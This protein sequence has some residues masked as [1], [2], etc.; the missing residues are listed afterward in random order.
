MRSTPIPFA[1]LKVIVCFFLLTGISIPAFAK[2][3]ALVIGNDNYV[4]VTKLKKAGNDANAMATE[5]RNAGFEVS[6]HKDLTYRAMVKA[7]D[8]FTSGITGGD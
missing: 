8:A 3:L 6:L 5:L 7:V 1:W 2:R 4:T